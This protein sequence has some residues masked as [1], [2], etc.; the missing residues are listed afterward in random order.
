[1]NV[2]NLEDEERYWVRVPEGRNDLG[3]RV[4]NFKEMI[5]AYNMI[6]NLQTLINPARGAEQIIAESL[7]LEREGVKILKGEVYEI[8]RGL[9]FASLMGNRRI[10]RECFS[11]QDHILKYDELINY[12]DE[13]EKYWTNKL[14]VS[15]ERI[16]KA[17]AEAVGSGK[18]TF[19]RQANDNGTS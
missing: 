11:Q 4:A 16:E 2:K 3:T 7:E 9:V 12:L 13:E 10:T 17:L 19:E 6:F 8:T 5:Y 1:M 15:P 14:E 18:M